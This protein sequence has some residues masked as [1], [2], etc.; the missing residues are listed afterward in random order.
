MGCNACA[1]MTRWL[2]LAIAVASCLVL[3]AVLVNIKCMTQLNYPNSGRD[4]AQFSESMQ[5]ANYPDSA[6]SAVH[7]RMYG[8]ICMG[9]Q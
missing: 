1:M 5:H 9:V 4:A 2:Y 6:V 3:W 8:K 7:D